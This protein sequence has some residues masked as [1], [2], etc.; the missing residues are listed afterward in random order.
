VRGAD[1]LYR[2][3]L[4][5]WLTK[6]HWCI[7][8]VWLTNEH[9][10]CRMWGNWAKALASQCLPHFLKMDGSRRESRSYEPTCEAFNAAITLQVV[11]AQALYHPA[12]NRVVIR[13]PLNQVRDVK[14]LRLPDEP[15]LYPM[16]IRGPS[17]EK[18]ELQVAAQDTILDLKQFLL[19]LPEISHYTH[20]DLIVNL[21]DGLRYQLADFQPLQDVISEKDIEAG[22]AF[23]EVVQRK[24]RFSGASAGLVP[25]GG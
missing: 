5:V 10:A 14:F 9:C 12:F 1:L 6:E 13:Q 15:N 8:P 24:M 4:L 11:L 2:C 23:L 18:T 25:G 16:E 7:F 20:Y 22:G 19:E 3:I 21:K 17:G